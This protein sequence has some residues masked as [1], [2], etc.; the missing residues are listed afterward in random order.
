MAMS[1]TTSI[2]RG[3]GLAETRDDAGK[4]GTG[5][6]SFARPSADAVGSYSIAAGKMPGESLPADEA[7]MHSSVR[8]VVLGLGFEGALGKEGESARFCRFSR[9]RG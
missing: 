9:P 4:E 2:R 3:S 8:K 5:N 6:I 1:S 7:D